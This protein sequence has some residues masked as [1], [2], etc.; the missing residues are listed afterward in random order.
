MLLAYHR[1]VV[2]TLDE[3][4]AVLCSSQARDREP[5]QRILRRFRGVV[6]ALASG[7]QS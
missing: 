3:L 4:V 6:R 7:W 5:Y 1:S 2:I